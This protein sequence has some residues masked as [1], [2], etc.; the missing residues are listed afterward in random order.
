MPAAN[1]LVFRRLNGGDEEELA[2]ALAE[3]VLV[4]APAGE[5]F[6]LI[7]GKPPPGSGEAWGLFIR[8]GLA[9]A[10]WLATPPS[11]PALASALV[12]PRGRWGK[13]LA[14]FML[15]RL[16][17]AAAE[18]GRD[19]AVSLLTGDAA[20]GEALTSAGFSGPDPESGT[21]PLGGWLRRRGGGT[22]A[23]ASV[24]TS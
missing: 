14:A 12:L 19:L 15:E 5:T 4:G 18:R 8:G 13:G 6:G 7:D 2:L 22:P 1:D 23:D 17:D 11:G 20:L 16:A 9:G 21:F 10:A 3:S 24:Y